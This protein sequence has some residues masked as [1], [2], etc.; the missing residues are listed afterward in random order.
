MVDRYIGGNKYNKTSFGEKW[1]EI[2]KKQARELTEDEVHFI[3]SALLLTNK[4]AGMANDPGTKISIQ[5]KEFQKYPVRGVILISPNSGKHIWI[6]KK[7]LMNLLYPVK[8]RKRKKGQV[9]IVLKAL[10]QIVEDDMRQE[11]NKQ[12]RKAFANPDS[13]CALS[14]KLLS[15]CKKTH[16]DHA[17]PFSELAKDFFRSL[18]VD[19]EKIDVVIKGTYYHLKDKTLIPKW[20]AYHIRHAQLQLTCAK[21]NIRKSNKINGK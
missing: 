12:R 7:T 14:G 17:Y 9:G 16:L 20:R 13:K 11:R 2:T 10:R 18:G 5:A 3:K 8:K 4:Y 1:S 15:E 21:A 6:G 19:M